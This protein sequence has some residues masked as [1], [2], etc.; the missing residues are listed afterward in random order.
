MPSVPLPSQ[1][2]AT[3]VVVGHR[4]VP[5]TK[6][7]VNRVG[8]PGVVAL[9]RTCQVPLVYTATSSSR[10]PSQSPATGKP[11]LSPKAKVTKGPV[12]ARLLERVNTPPLT[13]PGVLSPSP[14]QSPMSGTRGVVPMVKVGRLAGPVDSRS[15]QAPVHRRVDHRRQRRLALYGPDVD[16]G[17]A[18]AGP[19][20]LVDGWPRRDG[21]GGVAAVEGGAGGG[22]HVGERGPDVVGQGREGRGPGR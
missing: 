19:A 7:G 11:R 6:L 22:D 5:K 12:P 13:K 17:P 4:P 3:G 1:S 10:S 2:P 9:V 14:S 8:S 20:P 16:P 18:D 15:L 21:E